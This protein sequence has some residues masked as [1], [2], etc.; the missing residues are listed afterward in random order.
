MVRGRL[1]GIARYALE[2]ASRL[3]SLAPD[4]EFVALT[5]PG[6]LEAPLGIEPLRCPAK[7]LSPLEQ[8]ALR[9]SLSKARCDLFH[10][11]SFSVP[12]FWKGPLVVTLHDVNHLALPEN[13]GPGRR[14]YYRLVVA[15]RAKS[16]RAVLTDS[17]FSRREIARYLELPVEKIQVIPPGVD[18][19]YRPSSRKEL[20]TF[21]QKRGLPAQ[22]FAVVGNAKKHKNL[23]LIAN[24]ANALPAPVVLLAGAGA[25][26]QLGFPPSAVEISCLPEEEMP[27]FYSGAVALLLPSRYEGFGLPAL[28]AMAC[29]CP[30][31]AA[32]GS[33]LRELIGDA[34]ILV[35]PD[36][37]VGWIEAAARLFAQAELRRQLGELG[38]SR[39]RQFT[40]QRCAEQVLAVYRGAL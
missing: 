4:W 23:K 21:R 33:S 28:E 16:A 11:T 30:V 31:V 26:K 14:P 34:G 32:R 1:H 37:P 39:A 40:W 17:E 22:Y 27:T 3:P 29:E 9:V 20:D 5:A 24:L 36:E 18:Q 19:R 10:A 2:L 35:S 6:G 15:P 13:Y 38:R 8:L 7:F 25:K 12:A